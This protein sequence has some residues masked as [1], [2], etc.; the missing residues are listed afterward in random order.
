MQEILTI[1]EML[2]PWT[3]IQVTTI[4]RSKMK[5][6]RIYALKIIASLM[7]VTLA[8]ETTFH[9]LKPTPSLALKEKWTA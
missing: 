4:I 3:Q 6:R 9:D 1:I 8:L 2:T 7:T 5:K